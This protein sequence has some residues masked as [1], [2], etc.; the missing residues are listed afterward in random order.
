MSKYQ[1]SLHQWFINLSKTFV[2]VNTREELEKALKHA[3]T[4]FELFEEIILCLPEPSSGRYCPILLKPSAG[5]TSRQK[6]I[7]ADAGKLL[8][9]DG[10][11]PRI[12][13]LQEAT[14]LPYR[15]DRENRKVVAAPVWY[16]TAELGILLLYCRQDSAATENELEFANGFAL[17][18]SAK[19]SHILA[20]E[21]IALQKE[22][23]LGLKEK[24]S[25]IKVPP[26]AE[27]DAIYS[28][29][30]MIGAGPAMRKIFHMVSQVATQSSTVLILGETGT[31]K[32]VIAR[33]VHNQ[34]AQKDREMIKVNC[35]SLPT[36]LIESELFGHEK[37][38]FTGA[39]ERHIGKFELANN[40][41][42]FLDEVGEM[43]PE[44][45][46]KLLRALQEG[47][48]DRIGGKSTI[49]V[50]VRLIAATN[51]DLLKEVH[52]GRFRNDLYFRLNVF[53]IVLPPLQ[54]RKED[55]PLLARHFLKKYVG[56]LK[57][58]V[59]R[60]TSNAMKQLIAYNWPGNVRELEHIVERGILLTKGKEIT[61]WALPGLSDDHI[62]PNM[63]NT[64]LKTLHDVEREHILAVLK[65]TNGKVSGVGGAAEM[66]KLPATTLSS[67]MKK[68]KIRREPF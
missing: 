18:L 3:L 33:A 58:P 43:P 55:I 53:P 34:S 68:L 22:E 36:N 56:K 12:R 17:P 44:L 26:T 64:K 27:A 61:Q 25:N 40:S 23:I 35:A 29:D 59:T 66:L 28:P 45:Q 46:V 10:F 42:L 51:R 62:G 32:E 67:K 57:I 19:L 9:K 14:V 5:V 1:P 4:I 38:S 8:D 49:K 20:N 39:T 52:A 24:L 41:S 15:A 13:S 50:N 11:L 48:I 16:G 54:D 65:M 2:K 37:G 6:Q 7:L 30:E 31:G 47:E 63:R 21:T 60:I